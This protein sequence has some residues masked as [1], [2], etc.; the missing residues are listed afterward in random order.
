[1]V[2]SKGA[3]YPLSFF[4]YIDELLNRLLSSGI[5][6]HM[7]HLS[8]ACFGYADDVNLLAPSVGALQDWMGMEQYR[9]DLSQWM[10]NLFYGS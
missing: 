10:V 5:G 7:G 2:L 3:F 6:C 9:V 4:V 1:M 8:N